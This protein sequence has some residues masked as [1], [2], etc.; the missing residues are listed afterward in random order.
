MVGMEELSTYLL[1]SLSFS[2]IDG[3]MKVDEL[4]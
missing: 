1:N 4:A 3:S 2:I